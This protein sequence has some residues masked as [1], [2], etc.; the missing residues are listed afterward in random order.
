MMLKMTMVWKVIQETLEDYT[1]IVGTIGEQLGAVSVA[2]EYYLLL[3]PISRE[4]GKEIENP[5]DTYERQTI[6][7]NVLEI[8]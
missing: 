2:R 5:T 4:V 3:A 7:E 8:S 1:D 6:Y